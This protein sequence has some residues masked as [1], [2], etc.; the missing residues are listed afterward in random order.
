MIVAERLTKQ[1]GAAIAVDEA[2]F[3][4]EPGSLVAIVGHDGA[5]K[6]TTLRMLVGHVT[7]TEGRSSILGKPYGELHRPLRRVGALVGHGIHPSTRVR[8]HLR[9]CA[10]L[11]DLGDGH[12]I[13]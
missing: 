10:A 13:D 7:P 12:R 2:S 5:G 6:T 11:A 3:Q 9:I 8:D 4:V 1:F